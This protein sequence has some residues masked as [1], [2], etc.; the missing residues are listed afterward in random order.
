MK[1]GFT[2]IEMLVVIA[3]I[4]I[5]AAIAFPVFSRAKDS[6]YR[7]ADMSNMNS[8]RTALQLYRNDQGGYPPA[9]LGYA[10]TYDGTLTNVVPASKLTAA[11]YP[12]RI[13]SLN[14]LKPAF[15]RA[16]TTVPFE[17]EVATAVWPNKAGSGPNAQKYG[18][19][20]GPVTR[21]V[22]N[23]LDATD[24]QV[25]NNY[26][27]RISGYDTVEVPIPGNAQVKRNELR[28]TLF[29]TGFTV[30]NDPCNPGPSEQG[31]VNDD[32]RQLGYFDPP[33]TTVVT[34]DSWFREYDSSG[35]T[36]T[37]TKRDIVLFLGGSARPMDS[38]QV[39]SNSWKVMP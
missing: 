10:D 13:D 8:I 39:F 19:T 37:R 29:W 17:Q 6:A 36:P 27:Y 22:V 11:L 33:E 23:P 34:W 32:P 7:S 20:D 35:G 30:P 24:R 4:S 18:P 38:L 5:L 31:N 2:L 26:Y 28:Y 9:L 21:C 3:I 12:K 15:V 1:K 25:V 14:T 16:A